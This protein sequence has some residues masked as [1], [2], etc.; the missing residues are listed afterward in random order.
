MVGV[1]LNISRICNFHYQS[2][3]LHLVISF[4]NFCYCCSITVVPISCPPH[5]SPL[6]CPLPSRIFNP[7]LHL[8]FI[9]GSLYM[10]LDLTFPLVSPVILSSLLSGHCQFV[11]IFFKTF[12]IESVLFIYSFIQQFLFELLFLPYSVL[13][14]KMYK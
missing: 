9:Q 2:S 3:F 5:Y 7:S 8:V 10:L 4:L 1:K 12:R 6:P 11:Y 13:P 14:T